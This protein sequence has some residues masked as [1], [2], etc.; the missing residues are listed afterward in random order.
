MESNSIHDGELEDK[1][2]RRI[3]DK[4]FARSLSDRDFSHSRLDNTGAKKLTF[5]GCDFSY[6]DFTQAY[7]HGCS[8]E[9]C[10]FTGARFT[11]CNFRSARFVACRFEYSTFKSTIISS[12]QLLRNLPSWPN[13]RRDLLTA[14][15]LNADSVGDAEA[16][17]KFVREELKASR[18][19]WKKAREAREGYYAAKYGGWRQRVEVYWRSIAL[20]VDWHLWGHGEYP[21]R[22]LRA[23]AM[24]L[25]VAALLSASADSRLGIDSSVAAGAAVI[26]EHFVDVTKSFV[27]MEV[28][29]TP[30]FLAVI[31]SFLR[32]LALGLFIAVLYRRL[33]RR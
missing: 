22:L 11:E 20:W 23:M 7:F 13:V 2:V 33:S 28:R 24:G 31:L 6:C 10:N 9:E 18:E 27:G 29:R 1:P 3:R 8:F 16:A 5:R 14:L 25:V 19:H 12:E 26:W 17:R 4:F 21:W 30:V 32:Y 15:R